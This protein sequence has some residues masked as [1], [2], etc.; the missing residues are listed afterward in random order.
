MHLV[1]MLVEQDSSHEG[2]LVLGAST[3]FAAGGCATEVGIVE[4]DLTA[5]RLVAVLFGHCAVELLMQQLGCGVADTDLA[6]ERQR[7]QAC[8]GLAEDVDRQEP[9]R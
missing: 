8:L 5:E 9:G 6:F 4:L 2:R 7:R 1:A 3:G